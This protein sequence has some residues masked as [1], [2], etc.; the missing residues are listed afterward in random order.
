LIVLLALSLKVLDVIVGFL[1]SRTVAR[2]EKHIARL[3]T[4]SQPSVFKFTLGVLSIFFR[5]GR[6]IEITAPTASFAYSVTFA[7]EK[8][9]G[10]LWRS[11]VF[12][13][14]DRWG[15]THPRIENKFQGES[16]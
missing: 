13:L 5:I 11:H 7:V 3:T 14:E 9:L 10:K 6:Q 15:Y 8:P 1:L 12:V 2:K 4:F 16:G